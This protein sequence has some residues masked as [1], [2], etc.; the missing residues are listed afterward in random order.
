MEI[1]QKIPKD[2][3][4]WSVWIIDEYDKK[5]FVFGTFKTRQQAK[6]VCEHLNKT[7]IG[8]KSVVMKIT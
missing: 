2:T 7:L 5:Y 6:R 3:F 1:T 8:C 4:K